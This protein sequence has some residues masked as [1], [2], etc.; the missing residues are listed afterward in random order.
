[1]RES[2][3]WREKKKG[4]RCIGKKRIVGLN[5]TINKGLHATDDVT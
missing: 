2:C 5:A 3:L 4:V 1:M